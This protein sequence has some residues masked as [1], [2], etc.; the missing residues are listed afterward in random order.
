MHNITQYLE[1]EIVSR[2]EAEVFDLINNI[3]LENV[4]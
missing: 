4:M 2:N 1:H 3:E